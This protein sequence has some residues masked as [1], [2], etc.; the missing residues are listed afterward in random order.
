[1]IFKAGNLANPLPLEVYS[2]TVFLSLFATSAVL[3]RY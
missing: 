3:S 2:N 1:M